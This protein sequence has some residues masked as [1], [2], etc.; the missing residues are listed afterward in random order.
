MEQTTALFL[1]EQSDDA[2]FAGIRT[3]AL[4]SLAGCTSA[5]LADILD[6]AWAFIAIMLPLGALITVAYF[7]QSKRGQI[8]MTTEVAAVVTILI[9]ALCY[10]D[11]L[12]LAVAVGVV[13]TAL[14][15]LKIELHGF[16]ARFTREDI[17]AVIKFAII[18]A[19]ILPVLPNETFGPPPFNVLNPYKIWLMVVLISGISFLGY[20]LYK[21]FGSKKGVGLTGLLGG[22]ASSTATT[23]SFSHRSKKGEQL[24][25]P[26]ALAIT[27]AWTVMFVRVL[28]EVGA[29][30]S[31]LLEHLWIPLTAAGVVG[32]IFVGYLFFAPKAEDQEEVDIANPFELRPALTFGLLYAVILVV[33][34]AAHIYLSEPGIY[35]SSIVSGVA[36]VDAITLS[37]AELSR[38]G[39]LELPT[40]ARAIILAVMA[41]TL[42]K[43]AI[44][45]SAGSLQLR[46]VMIPGIL[47]ILVTGIALAIFI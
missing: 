35:I 19:I 17:L 25:K 27:I 37:M 28:V 4:F 12:A 1:A 9:G 6:T 42:V 5:Y 11:E 45:V 31:P 40:A 34:R 32:L 41:N 23:L 21:F 36:D 30:Y 43:G 47:A 20:I 14:L 10:W 16:V 15:S 39:N 7:I 44:V 18:T 13:T 26:F 38:S 29:V 3:F 8:G 33:A 46:K 22:L 24:A 2:T